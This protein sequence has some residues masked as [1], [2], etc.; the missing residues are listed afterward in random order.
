[1]TLSDQTTPVVPFHRL[2]PALLD[3]ARVEMQSDGIPGLALGVYYD[4]HAATAGLGVTNL[5]H[6]Q[7]VSGETLFQIASITKTFTATAVL[8]LVEKG[9]INLD[10]PVRAHL[11]EFAVVDPDVSASVTIR[12]CLTHCCGWEGDFY[13]DP[14]WGDDALAAI[15][16]R[17]RKLVQV[18]P[19][20]KIWSYNNAAFYVL[21]RILEV[22][23]GRTFEAV[24][25]DTLL[26]PLGI[27]GTCFFAHE[28]VHRNFAV[29]HSEVRRQ[30]VIARPCVMP[31]CG[32]PIGGLIASAEHLML[33]ARFQLEGASVLGD[34]MRLAAFEPAGPSNDV[35]EI[36]LGWWLDDTY[37]ERVVSHG[38]GA[39]GQPC[40]F[41]MVPSRRF[42]IAV[43]TNGEKGSTTAQR[44][45]SWAMRTYF[46]LAVPALR[47]QRHAI[48]DDWV[49]TYETCLER[50]VLRRKG[51][52][53]VY[54]QSTIKEWLE[55]LDP[56]PT[57]E[58][59]RRVKAIGPD[60]MRIAP[61]ERTQCVGT[62]LRDESGEARW[63][64]IKHRAALR[65]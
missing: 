27:H 50:H 36:G 8:Q 33:Y 47:S 15:V 41:A 6:P 52:G 25:N 18:T 5:M 31:R 49:G 54:D 22:L 19:L 29:G 61:G 30:R 10:D 34:A 11:P 26:T 40:F 59:G 16:G 39:N 58:I 55:G 7:P 12:H 46:G 42:A 63:L 21:G 1:M 17:M 28:L 32:N 13:E 24:L 44:L 3:Q 38:G 62:V 4:G 51:E 56:P 20:G 35:P 43:L 2:D 9:R 53:L 65:R 14:G 45:L 48:S 57:P 37:G 60:T 64:R 23:H